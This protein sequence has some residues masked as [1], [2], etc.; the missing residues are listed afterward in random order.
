[1]EAVSF[2][3]PV[4]IAVAPNGGRRIKADHPAIPLTPRELAH[5]AA[6]CLEAGAAMIHAHV[7]KPNGT[8]LL[9]AGAYRDAI[10]AIH[11]VVG[12]RM[13]IQITSEALGIYTPAE[14][15]SVVREVKPEAVSLALR[16]LVP[17]DS[18]EAA[19]ADLLAWM[20]REGVVPQIILYAPEEAVRLDAMWRRGLVPFDRI[21]VLYVLGRYTVGQTSTPAA[22]L[23]FLAPEMPRF[24]HWSVCAFGQH[25]TAC[26]TAGA[27]LGGHARVGFE[28]NLFRPDGTLADTNADLVSSV[29]ETIRGCGLTVADADDLRRFSAD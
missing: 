9:D 28:N 11:G 22:L 15:R 4:V 27:L 6:E 1:M 24:A 17:D 13:V 12:D 2:P 29:A 19:F 3:Q 25:E 26:V 16:E 5:T 10:A 8:H 18:E 23:P 14:Q 20:K 21:P 7:R